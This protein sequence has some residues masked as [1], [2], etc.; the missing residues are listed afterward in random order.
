MQIRAAA[1]SAATSA[2]GYT[3]DCTGK[4]IQMTAVAAE[5][6]LVL[7]CKV[8]ADKAKDVVGNFYFEATQ[9]T[10]RSDVAPSEGL[11]IKVGALQIS[12]FWFLASYNKLH[13]MMLCSRC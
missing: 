12:S 6:Y 9:V 3:P 1:W 2:V 5:S 4:N 13:S 8:A 11:Y 10:G 7:A